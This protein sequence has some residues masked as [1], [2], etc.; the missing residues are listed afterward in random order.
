MLK[1]ELV[2]ESK[3]TTDPEACQKGKGFI[4]HLRWYIA[5]L[6]LIASTINYLDRQ[7]LSIA[8]PI[9]RDI[10]NMSNTD[11]S[12]IVQAFL[13]A[14][15]IM[16]PISGKIIDWMGTRLG[17]CLAVIWWSTANVLTAFAGSVGAFSIY[18]FLLGVGEAGN[19]PASIKTVSEWFPAKERALATGIFNMGAGFG[20][21][22]A[23]P[24]MGM[25][26]IYWGWQLGFIITGSVGFLWVVAWLLLFQTPEKH[27]RLCKAEL[28]YIKSTRPD[29]II[30]VD[31]RASRKVLLATPQ[32]WG[33][34][35][36]KFL[37]D[38]V[39]WFYIFW[40]PDYLKNIRH[41]RLAEIAMFAWLPFLTSDFGSVFGGALSSFFI[42]RGWPTL[43]ARKM[44]LCACACL[45]PV[46]LLAVRAEN[47]FWAIFFICIATFG[48]NAWS[49]NLLTLPAD[50]F[51]KQQVATAYGFS[52]SA[53]SL[54]GLIFAGIIG[55]IL[56]KTGYV[57]V[58]TMIGFM[59]I[60]AAIPILILIRNKPISA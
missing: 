8:A 2:L 44:A 30:S 23:P 38:P 53:G 33:C 37:T 54:G 3:Q 60:I 6:L 4:K 59:H 47:T 51:A 16:L 39:W 20:A 26:I 36:G 28:E 24:L 27:H 9:L 18:R 7:M 21:I 32:L 34:I 42:R 12:H 57:P 17:F 40:L 14:Y 35:I 19:W 55:I 43:K 25:I 45:M 52:G 41:F 22:L 46:A 58:F 11:Y 56:D 1:Q 10:F 49:A 50:L 29:E 5:G 48:H 31:A 13:L 15:M